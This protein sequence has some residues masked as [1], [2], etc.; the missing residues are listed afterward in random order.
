MKIKSA[1]FLLLLLGKMLSTFAQEKLFTLLPPDST[2]VDFINTISDSRKLNVISYE[3][4]YNGSGVA[5]G[6]V[7]NDGLPDIY[8]TSNVY[9]CKLYL[10][11]G[12][13]KFKDVT[14]E[15]GVNGNGGYKTGVVMVDINND[16]WT[17]I[18]VC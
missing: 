6:D 8:F 14:K 3:Y 9:D 1:I 12:N 13:L 4:Y 18:Y 5:I 11:Q 7:N 15:A 16:G 2:K 10:N 17:D